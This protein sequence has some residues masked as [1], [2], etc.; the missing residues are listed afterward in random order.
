M[1]RIVTCF[2]IFALAA[3]TPT[4]RPAL[5]K[6]DLQRIMVTSELGRPPSEAELV[7]LAAPRP[8]FCIDLNRPC[9]TFADD[10]RRLTKLD[11]WKLRLRLGLNS[12]EWDD[13]QPAPETGPTKKVDASLNARLNRAEA[14]ALLRLSSDAP[15]VREPDWPESCET[16]FWFRQPVYVGDVAFIE[17][18]SICGG[19]CGQGTILALE[20]RNGHW[21]LNAQRLSWIV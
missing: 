11:R 5:T 19:L 18:G 17:S 2:C 7:L 3:C 10:A 15:D 20:Y 9:R 13:I 6:A 21:Q 1:R 8:D 4:A 12:V 14:D 16:K